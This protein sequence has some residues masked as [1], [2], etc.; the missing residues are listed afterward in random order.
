MKDISRKELLQS[1]EYWVANI[2]IKL[3]EEIEAFM[4]EKGMN[5]TKL[6]EHLGC[7]K[8]Y[9]TQLLS[10]DFDNKLSKLVELSL[11][12]GK[13]PEITFTDTDEYTTS[14]T[15]SSTTNT[16]VTQKIFSLPDYFFKAA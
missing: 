16:K 9:V 1:K 6:A 3:F 5:R 11:A 13:I 4:K 8:G 15:M 12:I 2:Q 10:G 14:L 7:T